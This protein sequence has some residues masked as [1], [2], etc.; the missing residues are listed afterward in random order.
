MATNDFE[1]RPCPIC[2]ASTRI[3]YCCGDFFI[4][5]SPGCESPM[6]D[7]P[8]AATTAASWNDWAKWYALQALKKKHQKE[9]PA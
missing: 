5:C 2:G 3:D 4:V 8:A 6:C 1:L 7:H 9:D